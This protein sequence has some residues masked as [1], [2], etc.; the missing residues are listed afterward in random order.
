MSLLPQSICQIFEI[1][2]LQNLPFWPFFTLKSDPNYYL[3][4]K[5][6]DLIL[7]WAL[8]EGQKVSNKWGPISGIPYSKFVQGAGTLRR[9]TSRSCTRSCR[10]MPPGNRSRRVIIVRFL[11]TGP[12]PLLMQPTCTSGSISPRPLEGSMMG[13][14]P[15]RR[16][17]AIRVWSCEWDT[18]QTGNLDTWSHTG[19]TASQPSS[20]R[21]R[22][23]DREL[24]WD[25]RQTEPD[26]TLLYSFRFLWEKT[27][28]LWYLQ[29]YKGHSGCDLYFDLFIIRHI[30]YAYYYLSNSNHG[31]VYGLITRYGM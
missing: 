27:Q 6:Y 9:Q 20:R 3:K 11:P 23:M 5:S 1:E 24:R 10:W 28:W 26:K 19:I 4:F 17:S 15:S 18:S 25:D 16:R 31:G 12:P 21:D 22:R 7:Y 13:P 14:C 30:F 8:V 29:C 2:V